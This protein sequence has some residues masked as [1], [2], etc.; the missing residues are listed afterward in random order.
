MRSSRARGSASAH[1]TEG[2]P[3][4]RGLSR[5]ADADGKVHPE[6]RTQ[7]GN[8]M[9]TIKILYVGIAATALAALLTACLSTQ[10]AGNAAAGDIGGVVHRP[11]GPEARGW[12]VSQTT[13]LP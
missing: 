3:V 10:G 9:K 8:F 13:D 11:S 5:L 12:V 2:L 6:C 7:K 4:R 1:C